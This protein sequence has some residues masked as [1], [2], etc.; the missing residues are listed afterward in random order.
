MAEM[1]LCSTCYFY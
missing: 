1:I